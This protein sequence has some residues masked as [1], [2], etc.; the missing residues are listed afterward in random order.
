[1]LRECDHKIVKW[2][3]LASGDKGTAELAQTEPGG[4]LFQ[5]IV[6]IEAL[7]KAGSVKISL[8]FYDET[9]EQI[10]FRWNSLPY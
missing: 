4:L 10:T 5:W 7:A 1:L 6:P 2:H 8:S 3:N 9:E